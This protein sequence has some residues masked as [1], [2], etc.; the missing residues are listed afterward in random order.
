MS[1]FHR[2]HG[3]MTSGGCGAR[4]AGDEFRSVAMTALAIA[5]SDFFA[6]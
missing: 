6:H 4:W 1:S 3:P 2:N 5:V